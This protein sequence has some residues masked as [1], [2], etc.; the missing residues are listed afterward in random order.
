MC[1]KVWLQ[2]NLIEKIFINKKDNKS[3][4]IFLLKR[5]FNN[6]QKYH[7]Y[8]ARFMKFE[9]CCLQNLQVITSS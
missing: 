4:L 1:E 8:R 5:F 6:I 7:W 2:L 9:V 3:T